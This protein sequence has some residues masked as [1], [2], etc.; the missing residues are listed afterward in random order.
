MEIIL[1]FVAIIAAVYV[2]AIITE[3]FFVIS[4]DQVS[5]R[6]ALPNDVAGASLM[7]VGSSA[8]E[9]FIAIIALIRGGE[10]ADVGIGT[11]VGSAVFNVLVITGAAAVVAGN[12]AIKRG[13]VERDIIV[14]LVSIGLLLFV[15]ENGEILIWEAALLVVVYVGYLVLLWVWSRRRPDEPGDEDK[16]GGVNIPTE[17]KDPL[18]RLNAFLEDV[19]GILAGDPAKQYGRSLLVSIA[20]IAGLSFVLV[21]SAVVFAQGVGVSAVIISIVILAAGTSAPDLI[22]SVNVAQGGRGGMAV[23]NAVGSNIFDVLVGLGFP[24]LLT[25]IIAGED[26]ILSTDGLIEAIFLL[27]VTTIILYFFLFTER[28]LTRREGWALLGTYVAYVAYIVATN[29]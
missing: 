22:A 3:D 4:L 1:S 26:V 23:A 9:L 24:W 25:I 12:M 11:I 7:A 6:L 20:V 5:K 21:E 10:H 16:G 19:L 13:A 29:T 17:G 27:S 18:S 14:Y 15:F 28:I 8:P 2:L